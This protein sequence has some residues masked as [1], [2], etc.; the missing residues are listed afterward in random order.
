MCDRFTIFIWTSSTR[1]TLQHMWLFML[2]LAHTHLLRTHGT[3]RHKEE[4]HKRDQWIGSKEAAIHDLKKANQLL[5]KHK[6]VLEYRIRTVC[7]SVLLRESYARA[8]VLELLHVFILTQVFA[9][10]TALM[11]TF[12]FL[13]LG[14]GFWIDVILTAW[15]EELRIYYQPSVS[16]RT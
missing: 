14:T 15:I 1:C 11:C 8:R 9:L 4:I 10:E 7:V 12:S 16:R 2:S 3:F 13:T 5:E 6:V